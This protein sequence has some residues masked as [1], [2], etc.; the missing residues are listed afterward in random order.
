MMTGDPSE[1]YRIHL[2]VIQPSPFC[3]IDC[4]Y[5]Y[6]PGRSAVDR[7]SHETL[8]Q[9]L[10]FLLENPSR[11]GDPLVIAWHAGEPL[12]LPVEFY[13]SAFATVR[14]MAPESPE[15]ENWFQTNATLINRDWCD[16][17]KRWDVKIGV[18]VDGPRTIH[19]ANRV[20]RSGRGTFDRVMRGIELLRAHQIEFATI[21]VLAEHSLNYAEEI[22]RFYRSIGVSS[23]AFN[24]E[25]PEGVHISSSLRS[26]SCLKKAEAFFEKLLYLRN[27]EAPEVFIRELDYFF[28]V[29]PR[30]N[31][32]FSRIENV[33]LAIVGIRWNGDVSTFSP[34]LIGMPHPH[35]GNFVFGNVHTHS[36]DA[37]LGNSAF[38]L[39]ARQIGSGIEKCKRTCAYFRLCGGGQPSSKLYQN[40]TF[41]SAETFACQ[42]RIQSVANVALSF[43]ERQRGI[44]R[45]AGD[46]IGHRLDTLS[47]VAGR[48][49]QFATVSSG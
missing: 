19:D 8:E 10:R 11:L 4:K 18:S 22:W 13:E 5:C 41:D 45:Q 7:M 9:T 17:I 14:Q 38:R 42:L 15:I 35:Y 39:V 32:E 21:G 16:F 1:V 30:C 6:L 34:E 37:V 3:N 25:E 24:F 28:D 20:D 47:S 29:V 49:G 12:T 26:Q 31:Q 40:G 43:L 46:S 36:L 2:V 33:P 23:L 27:S 48:A 44:P